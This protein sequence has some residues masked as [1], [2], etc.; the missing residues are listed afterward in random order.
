MKVPFLSR[1]RKRPG[2]L[3][4]RYVRSDGEDQ[5]GY[6][7]GPGYHNSD[8]ACLHNTFTLGEWDPINKKVLPSFVEKL[9]ARGYDMS[10]FRFSISLKAPTN[11]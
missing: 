8:M 10:T 2:V 5:M 7:C 6:V 9:I 3:Q 4:A 11:E 1:L